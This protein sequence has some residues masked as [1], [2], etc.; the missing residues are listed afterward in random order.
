VVGDHRRR[1]Q[2]PQ[3]GNRAAR[4]ARDL[5]CRCFSSGS[6]HGCSESSRRWHWCSRR[7]ASTV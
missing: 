2:R 1:P 4:A 3:P 5:R 7:S 6:Q